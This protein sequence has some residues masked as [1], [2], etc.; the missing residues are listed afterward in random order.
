MKP[1]YEKAGAVLYHG[2]A[3]AVLPALADGS[4]DAVVTD[5]PY[6]YA[7]MGKEWDRFG[8][9][10]N[11][12]A[13]Q[14]RNAAKG[15]GPV[16]PRNP[17]GKNT[18]PFGYS[19]S[20]IWGHKQ[21]QVYSEFSTKWAV[22]VLRVLKPGGYL[23]AFGGTRTFHR[24]ACALEDAGFEMR[25]TLMFLH[26]Q[27]FPKGRGCLKP[28]FE[29][30]LLCRKPGPKVLPLGIDA[31][32][33]ATNEPLAAH[34][35]T[36]N[37]RTA[38]R[39]GWHEGYKPGDCGKF[40]QTAGRWPANV[41]LS[42]NKYQLLTLKGQLPSEIKECIR[43][44]FDGYIRVRVLRESNRRY[45]SK[46]QVRAPIL[47][48]GMQERLSASTAD[49]GSGDD[50]LP[51]MRG[52]LPLPKG[53]GSG[54]SAEVLQQQVSPSIP[55]DT[56]GANVS[57]L[58]QE[59]QCQ[60]SGEN[61]REAG[62]NRQDNS[63]GQTARLEGRPLRRGRLRSRH[64]PHASPRADDDGQTDAPEEELH[65]GTPP[66]HGYDSGQSAGAG[67]SCP[68]P[69]RS[70]DGQPA[71]KPNGLFADGAFQ[72]ASGRGPRTEATSRGESP[73][74]VLDC[75]VPAG[76]LCYFEPTGEELIDTE[77]REAFAAFGEKGDFMP[78]GAQSGKRRQ[79]NTY[80]AHRESEFR[81]HGDTGTAARF[82]YTAKANRRDRGRGNTHP[83]VKPFALMEWLVKL[84]CP[85]GGTVL[86]PFAGSG[87]TLRACLGIGRSA[88]GVELDEH[89]CEIAAR[90]LDDTAPLFLSGAADAPAPAP[91]LFD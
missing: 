78:A 88:V 32:R 20:A 62:G 23:L 91:T 56:E 10:S 19:G 48:P 89:Y 29:P 73:L 24:L 54:R 22:A 40:T 2:D 34:K 38:M 71:G 8:G 87:S 45:A 39:N 64:D 31:C 79:V 50:D 69:E 16:S 21:W 35:G 90:R 53:M 4:A 28:A 70:E 44:Y 15:R 51:S 3:L 67:R 66:R 52:E 26:G 65:S 11:G 84:A 55:E 46:N 42:E 83:T 81:S 57:A 58:R 76:W 72:E 7:F 43:R 33:V 77:V 49:S 14:D 61:V 47:Q 59:A 30:I 13:E 18:Q 27:G 25:D 82:F 17:N 36:Q 86:D 6:G 41:V 60:V 5:P 80:G 75:D 1:Y 63:R 9:R 74:E 68:P 85:P 37:P 12:N